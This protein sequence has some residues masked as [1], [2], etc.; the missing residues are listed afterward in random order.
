MNDLKAVEYKDSYSQIN[1]FYNICCDICKEKFDNIK[2]LRLHFKNVHK[3]RFYIKC[4]SKKL[5]NK[6]LMTEH[7]TWHRN[8]FAFKYENQ[9]MT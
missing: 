2:D 5:F 9:Q 3:T 6:T 1:D 4:C 8:P 7:I